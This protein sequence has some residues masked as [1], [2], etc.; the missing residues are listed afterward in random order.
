MLQRAH[1][2]AGSSSA[3]GGG[4]WTARAPAQWFTESARPHSAPKYVCYAPPSADPVSSP[5]LIRAGHLKGQ[6]S[7]S[8]S[9]EPFG[10]KR[11]WNDCSS[12]PVEWLA[13]GGGGLLRVQGR[14]RGHAGS[15]DAD[16]S[17]TSAVSLS[18]LCTLVALPTHGGEATV[19]HN[20][21]V[22]CITTDDNH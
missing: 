2:G 14:V 5:T 10:P 3:G 16:V 6:R 21:P 13:G 18:Q 4:T 7:G 19:S 15:R 1:G 12:Q 22:S 17:P 9:Q 20:A 11:H 8:S